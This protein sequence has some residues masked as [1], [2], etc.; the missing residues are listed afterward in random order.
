MTIGNIEKS[1]RRK[2]SARATVLL[3][4]IPVTKLECFTKSKRS[5]AGFQ[6][7]HDCMAMLLDPLKAAGRE[8]IDMTCSDGFI[9]RVFPILAAYVADHPEQC[10]VACTGEHRCPRCLVQ[11]KQ[12]GDPVRSVWR[13]HE[14]T[15]DAM[16]DMEAGVSSDTFNAQGLR[17]TRPFWADLPHCDIFSCITPDLLHQLH[18]GVFKDHI[19]AWAAQCVSGGQAEIDQRFRTMPPGANLRHFKKGI[20][21]IS[22]WTGTEYK[23][24]EKL[25][26]GVLS[27]QAEPGLIRVVRATLD[28]IYFAHFESH[29]TQSL[30]HLDAAWVSFHQNKHYFV[31]KGIRTNF[32]IPKIHSMHHYIASIMSRGSADG[33]SSEHPERLHI[34]FAKSAYRA[35]N[36][37]EYIK[38]M[39]T[40][41]RRQD[42][43]HRFS[44]YLNWAAPRVSDNAK[45]SPED[46]AEDDD[47]GDNANN[48]D[49]GAS[50]GNHDTT[51]KYT[52]AKSAPY[53]L[54]IGALVNEFG[55]TDFIDRLSD[56]LRSSPSAATR[57][58]ALRTTL[59]LPVYK[60]FTILIPPVLQV[61]QDVTTD[62]V[63]TRRAVARH[64]ST[65]ASPSRFDTILVRE[66]GHDT[67]NEHVLEGASW[68]MVD[69]V[70]MPAD[71]LFLLCRIGRR[72]N[73]RHLSPPR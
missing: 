55:A 33:F 72:P 38:Q 56:F 25:F 64:G 65:A 28:F 40:W 2:P 31:D 17:P 30:R 24:M 39:T 61:T 63:H 43:C 49:G 12:L 48:D 27:G 45:D 66:S 1:I 18:K 8:G 51:L 67:E 41:L 35:T 5:A 7:F 16:A 3:G 22:Q 50:Q 26:L 4:Y 47:P 57:T 71:N 73:M 68:F 62:V 29:T 69:L 54:P 20:S 34:D 21:L 70:T 60:Q 46:G 10:L 37:R 14:T 42:A 13:D 53:I 59:M 23:N 6:I 32:S 44:S 36:K 52:I 19:V 11:F 9:R 15:L 58:P